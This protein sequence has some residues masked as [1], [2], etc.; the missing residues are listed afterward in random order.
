MIGSIF[1]TFFLFRHKMYINSSK[2]ILFGFF[3]CFQ[4]ASAFY[5][6]IDFTYACPCTF[7]RSNCYCAFVL[8]I[9]GAL[10]FFSSFF[11]HRYK[12]KWMYN[13]TNMYKEGLSKWITHHCFF[14]TRVTLNSNILVLNI[15]AWVVIGIFRENEYWS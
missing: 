7:H 2:K 9:G 11:L 13:A 10:I 5:H 1:L 8:I 3:F 4:F 14:S 12:R 15:C 6:S